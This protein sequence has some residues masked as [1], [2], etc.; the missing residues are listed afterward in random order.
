MIFVFVS[1]FELGQLLKE[2]ICSF[3][4]KFFL[5]KVDLFLEGLGI[6]RKA[7]RKSQKLFLSV[8]KSL[9]NM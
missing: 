4:S 1:Y 7:K 6:S 2:R 9:K 5:L 8:N 3:R